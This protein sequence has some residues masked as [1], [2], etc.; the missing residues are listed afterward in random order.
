MAGEAQWARVTEIA[1]NDEEL[2]TRAKEMVREHKILC[3]SLLISDQ[4][5]ESLKIDSDWVTGSIMLEID[6]TVGAVLVRTDNRQGAFRLTGA[7]LSEEV[8]DFVTGR[9]EREFILVVIRAGQTGTCLDYPSI[10]MFRR[11]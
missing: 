8:K 9:E 4:A 1:D 11:S 3:A 2:E 5:G 7:G 6:E 10:R